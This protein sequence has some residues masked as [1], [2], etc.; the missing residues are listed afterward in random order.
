MKKNVCL[1]VCLFVAGAA[2]ADVVYMDSST[3]NPWGAT[4]NEASMDGVFGAGNWLDT[5]FETVNTGSLFSAAT[6]FIFMEGG[7]DN[8]NELEAFITANQTSMENWV[9]S[10]GRL[11]VNS[12]PNE[13][14]GMLFGFGVTLTYP[15]FDNDVHGV[16]SGHAIFNGP[17]GSTGSNFSGNSFSHATVSGVGL[18][19]LIIDDV[20]SG[21]VL[22][23]MFFGDGYAM[24][25]GMTTLNFQDPNAFELRQ[26]IIHY[27]ANVETNAVPEPTSLALIGLGL[28]GM[29]FSRKKKK[30]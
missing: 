17:F 23:D 2:N 9:A 30:A 26:N 19:D 18:N 5:T 7:D 20:T 28:A 3:G 10:G 16:D 21:I 4:N 1:F 27:A 8:A 6:D 12:A 14:D 24:F 25:G 29:S 11:I 22:G 13:G 15:A